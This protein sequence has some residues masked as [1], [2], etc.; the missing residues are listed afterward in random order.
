[1]TFSFSWE[2]FVLNCPIDIHSRQ[3]TNLKSIGLC[4]L[5]TE[6]VCKSWTPRK[7]SYTAI[8]HDV[9]VDI[10]I[11]GDIG[12]NAFYPPPGKIDE[13]LL[14]RGRVDSVNSDTFTIS[15]WNELER[16]GSLISITLNQLNQI[17]GPKFAKDCERMFTLF[18]KDMPLEVVVTSVI[19][20]VHDPDIFITDT[21][22]NQTSPR[23]RISLN[24]SQTQQKEYFTKLFFR[25][26]SSSFR[27]MVKVNRQE[28][29]KECMTH[30]CSLIDAKLIQSSH[31]EESVQL[32][33]LHPFQH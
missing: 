20:D 1:M 28:H 8:D 23:E 21:F 15:P 13:K 27:L 9:S 14:L 33:S 11:H 24:L 12:Q 29:T 10:I 30:Q 5:E 32:N 22:Q 17:C 7:A 6:A 19:P 2:E 16:T 31:R 18:W 4:I 3:R 26:S 25:Y